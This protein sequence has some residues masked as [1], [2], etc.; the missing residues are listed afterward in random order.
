MDT[1][2]RTLSRNWWL[3]LLQGV[4]S[5]VLGVLIVIWPGH[6]LTVMILL[7]GLLI[8]VNGVVAV[9]AAI[10]A[11]GVQE[12]WAWK[13]TEGI[14]G[15]IVGL[16]ILR[17]PGVTAL[18]AVYLV[19]AWALISGIMAI[20]GAIA[21]HAVMRQAWLVALAGVVSVIFGVAMFAMPATASTLTLAYLVG[22]YAILYG[23]ATCA[24]GFRIRT[25]PQQMA[26]PSTP[27]GGAL[28]A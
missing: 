2:V 13:L 14:L 17:W 24:I 4:L 6:A 15:I 16:A 1:V 9:F 12:P 28:P 26:R 27:P 20:V 5:L 25:L 11:A 23:L 21:D 10:G 3:F 7:F 8:L 22:I 19:G 18:I